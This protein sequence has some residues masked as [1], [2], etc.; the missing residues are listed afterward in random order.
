MPLAINV[1]I[2]SSA[3]LGI[4]SGTVV[5]ATHSGTVVHGIHSGTVAATTHS[6]TVV[7]ATHSGT[8]ATT[9]HSGTTAIITHSGTTSTPTH[10]GTVVKA[11]HSGTIVAI[12]LYT[13]AFN[14]CLLQVEALILP[15]F[16][17]PRY[18]TERVEVTHQISY[19]YRSKRMRTTANMRG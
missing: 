19:K 1:T 2:T 11:T 14:T 16:K 5:G 10:S 7:T 3:R 4:H 12:L 15:M 6:G 18:S 8:T 17:M 9:I 13:T